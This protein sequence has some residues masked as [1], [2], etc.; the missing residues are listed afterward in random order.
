MRGYGSIEGQFLIYVP[1]PLRVDVLEAAEEA[2]GQMQRFLPIWKTATAAAEG[3][4][5][6]KSAASRAIKLEI[7]R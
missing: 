3:S 4:N 2:T 7:E 5:T 1:A 6:G